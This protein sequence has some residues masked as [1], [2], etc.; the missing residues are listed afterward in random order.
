M[1]EYTSKGCMCSPLSQ[2]EEARVNQGWDDNEDGDK[3]RHCEDYSYCDKYVNFLQCKIIALLGSEIRMNEIKEPNT[4]VEWA[5]W[6]VENIMGWEKVKT[7]EYGIEWRTKD[8]TERYTGTPLGDPPPTHFDP[9][10]DDNCAREML[11]EWCSGKEEKEIR[12]EYYSN[13][14]FWEIE[15][16]ITPCNGYFS[17]DKLLSIAACEAVWK[18]VNNIQ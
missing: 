14:R 16:F 13:E 4:D 5:E 7:M 9:R 3:I 15:C 18:A 2:S 10:N 17:K 12:I 1:S 8:G 6:V 11:E